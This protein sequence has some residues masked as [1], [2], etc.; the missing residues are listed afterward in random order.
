M[1]ANQQKFGYNRFST[2]STQLQSK[3]N[4]VWSSPCFSI[5]FTDQVDTTN[6]M[7]L[8]H[9]LKKKINKSKKC[10][11]SIKKQLTHSLRDSPSIWGHKLS[12]FDNF[13]WT[14]CIAGPWCSQGEVLG[15]FHCLVSGPSSPNTNL[16]WARGVCWI[17]SPRVNYS[18]FAAV[19][20]LL[21]VRGSREQVHNCWTLLTA[22]G[23]VTFVLG[24]I[25]LFSCLGSDH[26][27]NNLLLRPR[28]TK[29]PPRSLYM[30]VLLEIEHGDNR[31]SSHNMRG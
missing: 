17:L 22:V 20:N 28:P 25:S 19:R 12:R 31:L 9:Q 24:T 18:P 21:V 6:I 26:A 16:E 2:V 1:R 11:L 30:P 14:T 23:N 15:H 27:P 29:R 5:W 13:C 8:F 3:I 4:N 10:L 7:W